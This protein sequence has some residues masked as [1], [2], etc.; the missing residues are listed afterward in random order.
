MDDKES[1]GHALFTSSFISDAQVTKITCDG[2]KM[3]DRLVPASPTS[4]TESEAESWSPCFGFSFS[5]FRSAASFRSFFSSLFQKRNERKDRDK[6]KKK[7]FDL[8]GRPVREEGSI[9]LFGRKRTFKSSD[10]GNDSDGDDVQNVELKY[11]KKRDS[12]RRNT[13][14]NEV[15]EINNRSERGRGPGDKGRYR[16]EQVVGDNTR[17]PM[18]RDSSDYAPNRDMQ[19][20]LISRRDI[21]GKDS[22]NDVSPTTKKNGRQDE[23]VAKTVKPVKDVDKHERNKSFSPETSRGTEKKIFERHFRTNSSM[24]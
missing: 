24:I 17:S 3:R 2:E 19:N 22:D 13:D 18:K 1:N 10:S 20:L 14:Q 23:R 21:C 16:D 7:D 4:P 5:I 11:D 8:R 6:R 9:G 12:Q 15:R